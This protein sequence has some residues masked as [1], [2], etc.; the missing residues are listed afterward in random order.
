MVLPPIDECLFGAT[1][2]CPSLKSDSDDDTNG[3]NGFQDS[4]SRGHWGQAESQH[5]INM[6]MLRKIASQGIL[7][8]GSFRAIAWRVLLEYVP[9]KDISTSWLRELPPQRL[10]YASFVAD[11]FRESQDPG[12]ELVGNHSKK[13]QTQRQRQQYDNV[14]RL[15]YESS[16]SN[17]D[18]DIDIDDNLDDDDRSK[19]NRSSSIGSLGEDDR[20]DEAEE[21]LRLLAK[22]QQQ[23]PS[24]KAMTILEQLPSKFKEQWKKS[25]LSIDSAKSTQSTNM[26]LGSN[27]LVIPQVLLDDTDEKEDDKDDDD[28]Q[29]KDNEDTDHGDT[30]EVTAR[31]AQAATEQ[32][33]AFDQLLEHAQ[34]LEEIRKDVVRTH[35][36]LFFF[37][38]PHNNLGLRRYAALERILFVWAKLNKGVSQ[39]HIFSH[40]I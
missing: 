35:P 27:Q 11:Y 1:R 26:A 31:R 38:E 3:G 32:Q 29:Q 40:V 14:K 28:H 24:Q 39:H 37:L 30:L 33:Q 16:S 21:R 34:L 13:L 23:P 15:D 9:P 4:I 17:M 6:P 18:N 5:D 10:L 25:G 36:D 22:Q 20:L 19:S 8:E 12:Q 2:T 7:D